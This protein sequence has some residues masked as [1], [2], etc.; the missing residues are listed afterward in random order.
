MIIVERRMF[1]NICMLSMC[2][3]SEGKRRSSAFRVYSVFPMSFVEWKK[4]ISLMIRE[5]I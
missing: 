5:L 2:D 4:I 3:N 1:E